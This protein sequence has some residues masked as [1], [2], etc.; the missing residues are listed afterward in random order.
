IE[1]Y[2]SLLGP[3]VPPAALPAGLTAY[4]SYILAGLR[5]VHPE[6]G[7]DGALTA[8]G[9]RFV[10]LAETAC[11]AEFKEQLEGVVLGDFFTRPLATLPGW[12]ATVNDYLAMPESGFDKPFFMGHGAM[13]TD[14]P[15]PLTA[16]YAARLQANGQPVTFTTYPADHSGT[17]IRSQ[18]D[19]PPFVTRLVAGAD[20]A[21]RPQALVR[22]LRPAARPSLRAALRQG[23]RVRLAG[24]AGETFDV[25]ARRGARTV[26]TGRAT[27]S[28]DGAAVVRLRF[29]AA[30]RRALRPLRSARV[31]LAAPGLTRSVTLR[32]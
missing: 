17:L 6:L 26:A 27:T 16:A 4:M 5:T 31:R 1:A 23:L 7:L 30:A 14:V 29:T 2:V 15:Y 25:V 11:Y 8:T 20:R 24:A 18:Q 10:D 3:G 28:A 22:A 9:R 19:T 21:V 12:S 13:D 32:R